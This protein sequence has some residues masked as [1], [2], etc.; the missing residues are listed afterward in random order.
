M[1]GKVG[2]ISWLKKEKNNKKKPPEKR[3]N[4][5]LKDKFIGRL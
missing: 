4:H 1:Q 2:K 3:P 5:K